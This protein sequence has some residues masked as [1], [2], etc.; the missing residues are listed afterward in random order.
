MSEFGKGL[1]RESC[2][3]FYGVSRLSIFF[4][5]LYII[6]NYYILYVISYTA[7]LLNSVMYKE[8]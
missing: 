6:C 8:I 7:H 1:R 5:I 4:H 3:V 2:K